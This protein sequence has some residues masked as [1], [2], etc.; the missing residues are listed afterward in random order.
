MLQIIRLSCSWCDAINDVAEAFELGR[1]IYCA[2]GH[3]VDKT[4]EDCDCRKCGDTK[5][6][7]AIR[8]REQER[9]WADS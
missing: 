6:L 3:R 2:C 7:F 4:R 5:R 1:A 9:R 8:E